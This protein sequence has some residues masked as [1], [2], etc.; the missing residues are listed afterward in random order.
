VFALLAGAN[1]ALSVTLTATASVL[2]IVTMPAI[3]AIGFSAITGPGSDLSVPVAPMI[4]QLVLL[5]LAPIVVGMR[6]RSRRP[7]LAERYGRRVLKLL[8]GE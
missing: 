5:V 3:M 1:T 6:V 8:T 7:E 4:G 2:A